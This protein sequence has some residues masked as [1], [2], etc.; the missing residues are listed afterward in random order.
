MLKK[1][2]NIISKTD[3]FLFEKFGSEKNIKSLEN[4]KE[5]KIIFSHLNEIDKKDIVRFVGGCIRKAYLNE[6]I[7]DIDLATTLKPEKVKE[8]LKKD[9][10][11]VFDTGIDHGTVT[12]I[13][14]NI[15]FEITTLREDISTDGRHADVQFTTSW[16]KD[17]LRR[18]FT[19]NAIYADLDGQ[20]FDPVNGASDLERGEVKFIGS[21]KERIKED[22][23]RILRYFRFFTQYSKFDYDEPTIQCIK[24][25]ING[26]NQ[27]ANERI[28]D[29]V[30]K[31]LSLRK[32]Y[33]LFDNVHS[34]EIILNIFP[35]F[36][37]W[38]RLSKI[39]SLDEE[40]LEEL[41]PILILGLLIIDQSNNHEYFCFK[42]K[43]SNLIKDRLKILFN[44]YSNL[45][46]RNFFSNN[47]IKKSL[48]FNDKQ[49]TKN[50]LF[51]S[52][53]INEKINNFDLKNAIDYLSK[54][55]KPKFPLSGD[56]L[57][58]RGYESGK[59][60]GII[61]NKLEEKWISNN[62]ELNKEEIEKILKKNS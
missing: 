4:L 31:I 5:A 41:D 58:L 53:F 21:A 40:L 46:D 11:K 55:K 47:N 27:I 37:N 33:N 12:A 1:I 39:K 24:Q 38:K 18:D 2:K 56:F 48:Y 25:N 52:F 62:F 43:T 20:I 10:I 60:I 17:A 6:N 8:K 49:V 59:K 26:L 51:F 19:I 50:L 57:K 32:I 23:L 3:R 22:Y 42:Y 44:N 36:K 14:N 45:A 30:K 61:L 35:Q 28:F 13:L 9:N 16:E 34:R 15:K 29:E 54:C 7:D